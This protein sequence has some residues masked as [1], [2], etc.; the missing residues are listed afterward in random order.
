MRK[1]VYSMAVVLLLAACTSE[2]KEKP[3]E[4]S[5]TE[6][7]VI[8]MS[9]NLLGKWQGVIDTPQMPLEVILNLQKGSG[10]LTVP[11]QGLSDL[12]FKSVEYDD[13]QLNSTIDVAGSL[14]IVKVR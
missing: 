13:G 2:T 3:Q 14:G 8:A 5:T 10:T 11:A 6:Q 4:Q 12:P 7:E 9:E 1:V